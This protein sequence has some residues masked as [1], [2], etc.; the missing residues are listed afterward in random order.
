M[1]VR[2]LDAGQAGAGQAVVRTSSDLADGL[3]AIAESFL[4]GKVAGADDAAHEKERAEPGQSAPAP[5][6]G[7]PGA[8]LEVGRRLL[9]IVG[10]AGQYH[11]GTSPVGVKGQPHARHLGGEV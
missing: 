9:R 4:A 3:V 6:D 1:Y 10:Q 7:L 2:F 8:E 11:A 5:D